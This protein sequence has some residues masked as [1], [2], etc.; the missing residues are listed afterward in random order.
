ML[1]WLPPLSERQKKNIAMLG[2]AFVMGAVLLAASALVTPGSPKQ[3][4]PGKDA[5][6]SDLTLLEQALSQQ[7]Q[8]ILSSMSGVGRVVVRVSLASGPAVEYAR[9]QTSSERQIEE[10][11][12]SGTTR[13]TTEGN[14]NVQLA[15]ARSSATGDTPV[16]VRTRPAEVSG[17]LVVAEGAEDPSVRARLY[18]ACS[19]LFGVSMD[20]ISVQPMKRGGK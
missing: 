2:A 9:N 15:I 17:V 10:K 19:V 3:A 8:E 18:E 16:V 11:A 4:N 20:R 13:K 5:T 1:D 7:A 12:E 6:G 14:Q